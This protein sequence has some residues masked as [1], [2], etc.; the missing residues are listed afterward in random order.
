MQSIHYTTVQALAAR[1]LP[2]PKARVLLEEPIVFDAVPPTVAPRSARLPGGS[3]VAY[4]DS[5][6]AAIGRAWSAI[7]DAVVSA[8]SSA[9]DGGGVAEAYVTLPAC[10][11]TASTLG[12]RPRQL[13]SPVVGE[14][15]PRTDT[16]AAAVRAEL[17]AGRK[18]P[19]N[20]SRACVMFDLAQEAAA[21]H[22]PS[23]QA[24]AWASELIEFDASGA[25]EAGARVFAPAAVALNRASES[26]QLV[27]AANG[28]AHP[29]DLPPPFAAWAGGASRGAAALAVVQ[30]GAQAR[31]TEE[32][33]EKSPKS[34]ST[35]V[36][37]LCAH[38]SPPTPPNHP[39]VFSSVSA[40]RAIYARR[41]ATASPRR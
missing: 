14:L 31:R 26:R 3:L 37:A 27:Q 28:G 32:A 41:P 7:A 22:F 23:A 35:R 12:P 13:C 2:P 6:R 24:T 16:Q 4:E 29:L 33:G 30:A 38:L 34:P 17:R 5:R 1:G 21:L 19:I 20:A 9:P 36:T 11:A 15:S 25:L 39:P 40:A 10:V 8:A 18:I